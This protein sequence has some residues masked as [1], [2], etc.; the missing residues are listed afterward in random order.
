L[1]VKNLKLAK[2][3]LRSDLANAQLDR[4]IALRNEAAFRPKSLVPGTIESVVV[5]PGDT[6][7]AGSLL[8]TL[9]ATTGSTTLEAAIPKQL[10]ASL[11]PT[12][13]ASLIGPEERVLLSGGYVGTGENSFG[14]VTGTYPVEEALAAT[15]PQNGYA[16]L[17]AP[18]Q[19]KNPEGF[20]VPVD[21]IRMAA[22]QQSV[23]LLN[24]DH[25]TREQMV[26]LGTNLGSSV[27]VTSG[28]EEGD[29]L[30]LDTSVL[31]GETIEPIR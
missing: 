22:G 5:R 23:V 12:G 4:A 24:A 16:S 6:V 17:A 19:P 14:F 10:V 31:P 7:A 2:E 1:A 20:I 13:I 25:S 26:V 18:L 21:A 30:V 15:L 9:R 8:A 29:E 27:I 3:R 28:L 11:H